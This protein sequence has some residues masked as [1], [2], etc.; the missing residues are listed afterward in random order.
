VGAAVVQS[1]VF[2]YP[3]LH[4]EHEVHDAALLVVL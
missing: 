4:P 2:L 3:A 1:E